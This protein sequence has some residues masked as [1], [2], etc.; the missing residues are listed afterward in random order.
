MQTAHDALHRCAASTALAKAQVQRAFADF[1]RKHRAT[2]YLHMP[3]NPRAS[4]LCSRASTAIVWPGIRL[5]TCRNT[6]C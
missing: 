3:E 1:T 4:I 6:V 5:H 2:A